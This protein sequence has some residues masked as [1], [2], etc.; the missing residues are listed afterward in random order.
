MEIDSRGVV[1]EVGIG[2][3]ETLGSWPLPKS[4]TDFNA[5]EKAAKVWKV[6]MVKVNDSP[7]RSQ[8][9]GTPSIVVEPIIEPPHD[10]IK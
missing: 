8:L 10:P 2:V 6:L 7:P 4:Q 9:E 3:E 5:R 1:N